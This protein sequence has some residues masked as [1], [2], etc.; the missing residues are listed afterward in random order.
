MLFRLLAY[1]KTVDLPLF[2]AASNTFSQISPLKN[3][4][5]SSVTLFS[6]SITGFTSVTSSPFCTYKLLFPSVDKRGGHSRYQRNPA[7]KLFST[8]WENI[9]VTES[10]IWNIEVKWDSRKI[11][12]LASHDK[13][14]WVTFWAAIDS[15]LLN[16]NLQNA[17]NFMLPDDRGLILYEW[18]AWD[19]ELLAQ[20]TIKS[21]PG[22]NRWRFHRLFLFSP[23]GFQW[24]KDPVGRPSNRTITWAAPYAFC[25]VGGEPRSRMTLQNWIELPS[26]DN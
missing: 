22:L 1:S 3:E 24:K 17:V 18:S 20:H 16:V 21:I 11:T 2:F 9:L 25:A 15:N 7:M 12:R 5:V 13:G 4:P 26:L 23:S 14:C 19:Q 8:Q 6:S 10:G